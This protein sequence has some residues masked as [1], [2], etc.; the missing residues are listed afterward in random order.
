[1]AAPPSVAATRRSATRASSGEAMA[2]PASRAMATSSLTRSP[3]EAARDPSGKWIVSS[4]PVR[5]SPPSSAARRCSGQISLRPIA[6]TL[7]RAPSARK[8]K[9]VGQQL[10]VG[11]HA[12][13]DAHHEIIFRRPVVAAVARDRGGGADHAEVETL[14][15]GLDPLGAHRLEKLADLVDR[16]VEQDR[17]PGPGPVGARLQ[18]VERAGVERGDLGPDR[19]QAFQGAGDVV[20]DHPGRLVDDDSGTGVA[21]RRDD[22]GRDLGV[23]GWP[24]AEAGSCRRKWTW[25]TLAPSSNARFASR[26]ISS[27]VTGAGYSAGLVRTPVSAQVT[28]AL[29]MSISVRFDGEQQ[30]AQPAPAGRRRRSPR[31]SRRR[32]AREWNIAFSSPRPSQAPARAAPDRRP[33]P[34]PRRRRR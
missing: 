7:Q 34:R 22:G 20:A 14:E 24:M 23:P 16:I 19:R 27:G 28:T 6:V 5:R 15:F 29:S 30:R 26:A 17:L 21:D 1:M 4:R 18:V 9:Q 33:S 8:R 10:R 2:R 13:F 3:F 12:G 31:R 11:R 32:S 25:T